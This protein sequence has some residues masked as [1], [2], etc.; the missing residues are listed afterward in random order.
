MKQ[1]FTLLILTVLLCAPF[2]SRAQISIISDDL[3]Y[4]GLEVQLATEAFPDILVGETSAESQIWNY[5]NLN[6]LATQSLVF[7]EVGEDSIANV[8]Y[9]NASMKNNLLSLF[10]GGELPLPI[11]FGNAV[12]YYSKDGEGNIEANG[13]FID[14][15]I[16][17]EL[18][19]FEEINMMGNPADDFFAVGSY[20]D[21]F[22]GTSTYS[23]NFNVDVDTLP[24]PV[25]ITI[26]LS[27]DKHTEIDA[28]GI[29]QFRDASYE[30]LRYS[31]SSNVNLAAGIAN[32]F[33]G[34]FLTTFF[35]TS[36]QNNTYR[37]YTKDK[38]YP[39]ATVTMGENENGTIV[40]ASIEYQVQE[41]PEPVGF[42]YVVT[43]L[44]VAFTNTSS[45]S[46]SHGGPVIASFWD[47]GDGNTSDL[48]DAV[49]NYETEG[50]YEVKLQVQH[51]NGETDA[52][53]QM[54]EVGCTDIEN[55]SV[56][57][58][59]I[60]PNPAKDIL[61]F[62]FETDALVSIQQIHVYNALGQRIHT[63]DGLSD[64]VELDVSDWTNGIYFYSLHSKKAGTLFGNRFIVQH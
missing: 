25:P 37:F 41:A 36:F 45:E 29:M 50:T 40:P 5:T 64:R 47:F 28:F 32:P 62:D 15:G 1:H 58:H 39:L 17:D 44:N 7:E 9:P 11:D 27:T 6:S 56:I 8:H 10:G 19:G 13:I 3:P 4:P 31:E 51:E 30:V 42:S 46:A 18:L 63:L 20:G 22:D 34:G 26:E 59:T 52:I 16:E 53:S 61:Y 12:T 21:V 2:D 23:F 38:G 49:H 55:L 35:D 60:Y 48:R 33:G 24:I 14:L 54:I 43:C 57:Y